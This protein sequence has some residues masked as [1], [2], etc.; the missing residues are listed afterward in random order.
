M[1]LGKFSR[2]QV[3]FSGGLSLFP[4]IQ[5]LN[6]ITL[7]WKKKKELG[8][9]PATRSDGPHNQVLSYTS[10]LNDNVKYTSTGTI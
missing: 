4:Y 7:L 3:N 5:V 10:S 8:L 9:V 2:V 6:V 1:G